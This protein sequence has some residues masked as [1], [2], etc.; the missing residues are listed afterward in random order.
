[1]SLKI[2]IQEK[3]EGTCVLTGKSSDGFFVTFEDGS[4]DEGFF[5][6]RSFIQVVSMKLAVR[7]K[8]GKGARHAHQAA[9]EVEG[10][11]E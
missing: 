6:H 5:S 11:H 3:G 2:V 8:N 10:A 4:G 7:N 9:K 1:M